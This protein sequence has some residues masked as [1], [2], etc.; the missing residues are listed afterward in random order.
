VS[1]LTIAALT[2]SGGVPPTVN[3]VVALAFFPI[4][5]IVGMLIAWRKKGLGSTITLASP[6]AFYVWMLA[7]DGRALRGPY[8]ALLAAPGLLF[9]VCSL[10]ERRLGTAA[11]A[12]R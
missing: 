8:F 5:V 11:S 9:L 6:A 7:I 3:E 10:L 1:T 4:G 12:A 2:T